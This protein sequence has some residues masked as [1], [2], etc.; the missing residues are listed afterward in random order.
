MNTLTT[1]QKQTHVFS[2]FVWTFGAMQSYKYGN[3]QS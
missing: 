1:K 3:F 2:T